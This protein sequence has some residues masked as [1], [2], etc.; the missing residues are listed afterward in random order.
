MTF[1]VTSMIFVLAFPT[2]ASSMSGY[3]TAVSASIK[4]YNED[5]IPFEKFE[6]LIFIVHDGDRLGKL[7]DH[8]VTYQSKF[9]MSSL[10]EM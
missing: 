2:L 8:A 10:V 7:K 4:D 5:A 9:G 6:L 1:M 3:T